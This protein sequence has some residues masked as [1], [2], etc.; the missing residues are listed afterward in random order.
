MKR[1]FVLMLAA[2]S[3]FGA[4]PGNG[5][6]TLNEA[7]ALAV[8]K[9]KGAQIAQAKID[10][11]EAG[12]KS[13]R[14][15][16]Y[17]TLTAYAL[18]SYLVDP[19]EITIKQGS[20][21]PALNQIGTD[22][23]MANVTTALGQ[24][25]SQDLVLA[26]GNRVPVVG[27]LTLAQPVSQ[28]FRIESGVKAA[29]AERKEAQFEADR[30]TAMLRYSVEELFVGCLLEKQRMA[31]KEAALAFLDRQ[32]RDA[33]NARQVGELL[34]ESVLGLKASEI[35]AK[36][37]LT[38]S[39]QR[40]AK[41]SLQL[42]D[43]IGRPGEDA[44]ELDGR[45]PEREEHP[46]EYWTHFAEE[47]PDRLIA[48]ATVEKATAG[49]RAARQARIPDLSLMVSGYAQD[50]I[51]VA[52]RHSGA[53]GLALNWDVFDFGRK[54]ADVARAVARRRAAELNRDRLEEDAGRE[55]RIAHQD[56]V[57]AGQLVD[58]AQQALE[59]R[60]R[61]AER[62][63]QSAANGLALASAALDADAQLRK[64]EAD[65]SG[66]RFQRHLALLRLNFL[67]GKL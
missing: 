27:V 23:G 65:L 10:E 14:S 11:A 61:A 57:Y 67:A 6:L 31:E 40:Y 29:K 63:R 24:F 36:A 17:P 16:R 20:L 46:L 42:G 43:L 56:F 13:A 64:A 30:T 5:P 22:L 3:L 49:V 60:L 37:E 47:N 25:P 34:E 12:L 32:L 62:V 48:A 58:L 44:L 39:R 38:R 50:G 18:G 55:I 45:L 8:K 15:L 33:E 53:V 1:F 66:A 51:P 19:L 2:G 41:L 7:V 21:T 26:R 52:S 54:D 4:E 59:Y 35:Q 9:S 28:L